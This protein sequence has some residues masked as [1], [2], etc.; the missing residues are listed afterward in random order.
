MTVAEQIKQDEMMVDDAAPAIVDRTTAYARAV[1]DGDIVT[2]DLVRLACE[3]HIRDLE[4]AESKRLY[5]K[6]EAAENSIDFFPNYL[7]FT[8]GRWGRKPFHLEPWQQFIIGSIFGWKRSYGSCPT[9]GDWIAIDHDEHI[10]CLSC[11]PVDPVSVEPI[12]VQWLRRFRTSY[13]EVARK[14]GKTEMSAGLMLRQLGFD[15]EYGAEVY[16]AATKSDQAKIPF[17]A[18]RK[19]AEMSPALSSM[20]DI[21]TFSIADLGFNGILKYL[22]SDASTQD[23]LNV[24]TSII[25][26]FHAH[27]TREIVDVIDTSTAARLQ[28]LMMF[29][30]TAGNNAATV[31]REEH[32]YAVNVLHGVF[33]DDS[34]FAYIAC[35][36]KEDDWKDPANW[37]KANPNMGVSVSSQQLLDKFNKVKNTPSKQD[38]FKQKHL[39]MWVQ[40]TD[41]WIDVEKYAALAVEIPDEDLIGKAQ[42]FG[43]DAAEKVDFVAQKILFPPDPS[44]GRKY[45]YLKTFLWLP[46]GALE[47]RANKLIRDQIKTWAEQGWVKLLPGEVLDLDIVETEVVEN[48]MRYGAKIMLYDPFKAGQLAVRAQKSGIETIEFRQGAGNMNEPCQEFERMVLSAELLIDGNPA[49]VWMIGNMVK[50][51]DHNGNIKADRKNSAEKIDSGVAGIMAIGEYILPSGDAPVVIPSGY[52]SPMERFNEDDDE[53]GDDV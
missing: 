26:E 37:I 12:E 22:S 9:C 28:P 23:G 7:V 21:Q 24:S 18:A 36:D 43:Y 15:G 5:F 20:F 52:V 29:I 14:N 41:S 46:E 27:K 50:K 39:N 8:K 49:D 42:C 13:E 44:T 40:S 2:G 45:P 35:M 47:R 53:D 16:A 4:E 38:A 17:N 25:E 3:R 19:M 11:N 33:D 48:A 34:Y 10:S 1:I 31:C 51:T 30:T 32:D 6:V